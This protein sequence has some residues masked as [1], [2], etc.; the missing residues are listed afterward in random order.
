MPW[1]KAAKDDPNTWAP[2]IHMEDLNKAL[3]SWLQLG[4]SPAIV[5]PG[6]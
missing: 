5:P 6:E 2:A 4:P 1:E 3:G